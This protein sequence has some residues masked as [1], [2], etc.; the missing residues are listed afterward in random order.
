MGARL[1]TGRVGPANAEIWAVPRGAS[2]GASYF[3]LT[4]TTFWNNSET[5]KLYFPDITVGNQRIF[6]I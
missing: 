4:V 2:H 1:P 5:W 6:A 3:I